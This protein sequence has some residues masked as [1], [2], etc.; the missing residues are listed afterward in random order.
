M[1]ITLTERAVCELKELMVSQQ[2][3]SAA[4]RI[5]VAGGGCS[6]LSYGMALDDGEPE[7]GDQVF[8]Q[9][10]VKVYIDDLSLQYM[11]GS[12]VDYVDD[13]MGGGFKIDNP[14]ATK[15]CGCGSSFQTESSSQGGGCGSCG[16]SG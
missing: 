13:I 16:C 5:W 3:I 11:A 4:L 1:N 6:G 15:S 7:G 2:K 14:N 9:M 10:G 12:T 8:E